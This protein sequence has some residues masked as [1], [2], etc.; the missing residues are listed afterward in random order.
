MILGRVY[1]SGAFVG[2]VPVHVLSEALDGFTGDYRVMNTGPSSLDFFLDAEAASSPGGIHVLESLWTDS[3][4]TTPLKLG[5]G[6]SRL[7]RD[8]WPWSIMNLEPH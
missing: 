6:A 7:A 2:H 4:A 5:D 3:R 8:A 1:V